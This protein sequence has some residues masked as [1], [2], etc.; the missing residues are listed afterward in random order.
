MLSDLAELRRDVMSKLA[1]EM[2]NE[3]LL[4]IT[5]IIELE[6]PLSPHPAIIDPKLWWQYKGELN[7]DLVVITPSIDGETS[8]HAA[9][10]LP[11]A[12]EPQFPNAQEKFLTHMHTQ[13]SKFAQQA[14]TQAM[15]TEA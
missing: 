12:D 13:A 6:K 14:M 7:A 3:N 15:S 2:L 1:Q 8:L 5:K 4:E 11:I 10:A 9:G